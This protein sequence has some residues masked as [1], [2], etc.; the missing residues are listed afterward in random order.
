MSGYKKTELGVIPNDWELK[1]LE[2][3]AYVD[4]DNLNTGT[5]KDYSFNYISLENV[6]EGKLSGCSF[7]S[8]GSAPSRARRR[9]KPGD[10][11]ISTVRPNL[12]SHLLFDVTHSRWICSTGFSVIRVNS[13]KAVAGYIF[14]HL[15]GDSISKQLNTL[16]TGSNY[17][18]I[19]GKDLKSLRFPL[20]PTIA[21]QRLIATALSEVDVLITSLDMLI[22]KKRLIKQGVM[23]ELLTGKKRLPGFKGE[24]QNKTLGDVLINCFSGATPSRNRIDY[25]KGNIKWITSSELNY[26]VITDTKEKISEEAF[27]DTNL[28]LLP[29]G[30]FLMAITGLEAEGTR[31]AC[32]IVGEE[33]TTNQSCMALIPNKE[34]LVEFLFHF[35]VFRGDTLALQ[36]CQGTKQQSYTAKTVKLLP[37]YLPPPEEQRIIANILSDMDAEIISLE[38]RCEK[39]RLLKQGMMQELL[40]GRIRLI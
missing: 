28:K 22:A 30:T 26:N 12:K 20:P 31:G 25:F 15:F 6:N 39:T 4:I 36:Y 18:A 32:G 24:W 19:S 23:Q 38:Q 8:Y 40:T 27:R 3:I 34:L 37:I 9:V 13:E 14:A 10:V 35:Y 7:L 1:C 5:P 33:A 21:E 11:L 29:K 17:P 16:I 2:E